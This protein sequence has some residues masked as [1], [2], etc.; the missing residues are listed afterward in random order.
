[1]PEEHD[2]LMDLM[3]DPKKAEE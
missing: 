3:G 1:T 2:L